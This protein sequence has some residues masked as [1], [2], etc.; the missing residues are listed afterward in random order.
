MTSVAGAM[1]PCAVVV[2]AVFPGCRTNGID[3]IARR[4]IEL[5]IAGSM[6]RIVNGVPRCSL[7][8]VSALLARFDPIAIHRSHR[9]P[10]SIRTAVHPMSNT[11]VTYYQ[12]ISN[13][14]GE[15]SER[16]NG[17]NHNG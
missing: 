12:D 17:I 9:R 6:S 16:D 7:V 10:L 1:N 14:K 13:R 4:V 8:A 2:V 15:S 3:N 11:R 5:L